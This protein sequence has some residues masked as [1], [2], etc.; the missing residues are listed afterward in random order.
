MTARFLLDNN[1]ASDLV[2]HPQGRAATQ[3][4]ELGEEAGATSIIERVDGVKI[5]NWLR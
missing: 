3:I 2:R 5:E 1:F 4:A